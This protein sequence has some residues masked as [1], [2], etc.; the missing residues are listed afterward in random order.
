MLCLCARESNPEKKTREKAAK[1][2]RN[3]RAAVHRFDPVHQKP[4]KV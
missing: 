1:T 3:S 4:C 2:S